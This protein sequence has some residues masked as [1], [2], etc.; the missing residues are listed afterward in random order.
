MNN[1]EEP[2]LTV[3]LVP[4]TCWYS[5]VRYE[6]SRE[7]WDRIRKQVYKQ[8]GHRCEICGKSGVRLHCHE[9]WEYD[10]RNLRQ[11]LRGLV[12]L[13][14]DCHQVKHI[15]LA[16]IQGHGEEAARHLADVNGWTL[17]KT[18]AYLEKVQKLWE[19]RSLFNWSLDI[20]YLAKEH[21]IRVNIKEEKLRRRS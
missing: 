21:R 5:N 4:R 12:A 1:P 19:E 2:K 9:I 8:A 3:E 11:I 14:F 10:D 17:K 6:V 18:D 7:E 13:C 15:G 20:S 16:N